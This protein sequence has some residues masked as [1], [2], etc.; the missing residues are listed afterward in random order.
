YQFLRVCLARIDVAGADG[1]AGDGAGDGD[2]AGA[3]GPDAE[4]DFNHKTFL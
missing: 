4:K 1:G 2:G 3:G